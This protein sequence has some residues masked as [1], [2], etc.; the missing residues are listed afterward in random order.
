VN[1]FAAALTWQQIVT[2]LLAIVVTGGFEIFRTKTL[3]GKLGI[4]ISSDPEIASSLGAN[5]TYYAILAFALG[6]LLAGI[7]GELVAPISFA[8]PYLG[9]TY[10]IDG[11]VALMIGGIDRPAA[12][13]GGGLLL[14]ILSTI[15]STYIN[16]QAS[17]WFPF[18]VVIVVLLATPNG[19]FISGRAFTRS[20]IHSLRTRGQRAPETL[21]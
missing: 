21:T 12:S 15:A 2:I 10:G 4:A 3:F 17:D 8:N 5:V 7:A 9:D 14:G 6:G 11:F 19:V 16:P 18:V 20:L 1:L 13:M